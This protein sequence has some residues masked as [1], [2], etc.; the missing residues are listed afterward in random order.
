MGKLFAGTLLLSSSLLF[1]LEPLCAKMLLPT[2]GGTPAV[3]N[4]CLVFFQAQLLL[5]YCYAHFGT[6]WLG[7]KWHLALHLLLLVAA[8][9]SLPVFIVRDVAPPTL[10]IVWL[11]QNLTLGVGLPFFV[12]ASSA[13]LLQRWYFRASGG[14]DPYF[15]YAASNLGSFAALVL[16]PFVAEPN[17]T[18]KGQAFAWTLG[19]AVAVAAFLAC[20]IFVLMARKGTIA[21]ALKP[22]QPRS[23]LAWTR[24]AQWMLFALVP[25]S[26]ML[27]VTT[28]LTTDIAAIPLLWIIPLAIYLLTFTLVFAQR[29][30]VPHHFMVRW[31]PLVVLVLVV[32]MLQEGTEPIGLIL[33]LHLLGLFWLAMV[34]HGE[35]ART[36]PAPAQ[37]TE[38][39]LWLALGGVLGGM[40]NALVAPRI[41]QG[42]VEYPLMIVVAC[43]LKPGSAVAAPLPHRAAGWWLDKSPPLLITALTLVLLLAARAM[44]ID[45]GPLSVAVIF[46]VP[47]LLVYLLQNRPISFGVSLGLVLLVGTLYPGIHGDF[48]YRQRSFFGI[49][50]VTDQGGYRK[51]FNGNTLHGEQSLD[52]SRRREPLTYYYP[53]GPIGQ[54]M[55]SLGGDERLQRVALIGLGTGALASYA[56]PGQRWTFF[57]ID[58]AVAH[59]AAPETGLFSY[60]K[61]S[62]GR[63]DVI[64]G[65]ARLTL[66]QQRERF[67]VIIVDAF[68]SDSIPLHLLT[69]RGAAG[70]SRSLDGQRHPGFPHLE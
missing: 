52:P 2:L 26:L 5:G 56:T 1:F 48:V 12:L 70:L 61:D 30:L 3:W 33:G 13:P 65:D 43:L 47:L 64:L 16:Y 38:F 41:F 22:A 62:P 4:T 21:L 35:L 55:R 40:F 19:Y 20:A 51:L 34:C 50:R 69:R 28:Y 67:G 15:L 7:V 53:T 6:R 29:Q 58:P 37:L 66:H 57:E 36:K 54:V 68:G 31:M 59:I 60:L 24:R 18:L 17:L 45:P 42:L 8:F 32:M 11:L 49:H 27:S 10:P 63:V 46:A 14:E 23:Q 39:Y 25:S 9:V 44:S